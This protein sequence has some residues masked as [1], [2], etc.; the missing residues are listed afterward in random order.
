MRHQ[1]QPLLIPLQHI[2][3][4]VLSQ[5]FHKSLDQYSEDF[6]CNYHVVKEASIFEAEQEPAKESN[7]EK[8]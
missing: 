8:Q 1:G 6:F 5:F 2:R 7:D 4:H 3:H